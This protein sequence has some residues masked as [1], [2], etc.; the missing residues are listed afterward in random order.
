MDTFGAVGA[1]VGCS[2]CIAV[3]GLVLAAYRL[4]IFYQLFHKVS[5]HL[6][7]LELK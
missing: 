6:S 7:A 4:G 2:V 3:G 5:V 1:V